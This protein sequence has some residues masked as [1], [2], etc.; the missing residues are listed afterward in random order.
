M[1]QIVIGPCKCGGYGITYDEKTESELGRCHDDLES[2]LVPDMEH[3][4][5]MLPEE[6]STGPY[7][8]FPDEPGI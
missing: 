7:Y 2:V 5:N 1:K 3:A 4:V 6:I 8:K